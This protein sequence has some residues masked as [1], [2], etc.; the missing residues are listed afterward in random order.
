MA[1][2]DNRR[3]TAILLKSNIAALYDAILPIYALSA[4]WNT[5]GIDDNLPAEGDVKGVLGLYK[6]VS[7]PRISSD[8]ALRDVE[9]SQA[10]FEGVFAVPATS[11]LV[12]F[13]FAGPVWADISQS[14]GFGVALT[15]LRLT[16]FVQNTGTSGAA[17]T[18][19]LRV[20]GVSMLSA[21]V[22]VAMGSGENVGVVLPSANLINTSV[23]A[24]G[25]L[26]AHILTAPND[27]EGVAVN[28]WVK[29]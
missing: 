18:V 12:P 10:G 3:I 23:P 16:V 29:S 26:S 25:V 8:V 27:A 19:D 2:I 1:T 4:F 11:F 5:S 20:D 7:V 14:Q 24:S 13:V 28:I 22:S 17:L 15:V 6:A 9:L 21:P